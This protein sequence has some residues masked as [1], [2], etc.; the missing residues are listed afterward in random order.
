MSVEVRV[1]TNRSPP[2]PIHSIADWVEGGKEGKE[3]EEGREEG[4]CCG[5][6]AEQ[7]VQKKES[8]YIE[9][10]YIYR[11]RY[12]V[13]RGCY[14]AYA[15]VCTLQ[16]VEYYRRAVRTAT[17]KKKKGLFVFLVL[18]TAELACWLACWL[19]K[20]ASKQ[21]AAASPLVSSLPSRP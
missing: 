10:I 20:Q 7:S 12:R 18:F 17:E 13:P 11:E 4:L 3:G 19:G 8:I 14:L 16:H 1:I 21:G 6:R 5:C 9:G 2:S 15:Y